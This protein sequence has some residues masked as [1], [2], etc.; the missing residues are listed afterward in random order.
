MSE[1]TFE[2][3]EDPKPKS[4]TRA[5]IKSFLYTSTGTNGTSHRKNAAAKHRR[6]LQNQKTRAE[7]YREFQGEKGWKSGSSDASQWHSRLN[8]L[9]QGTA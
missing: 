3:I 1:A 2:V 6:Y 7:L 8:G 9:S 5:G 4:K